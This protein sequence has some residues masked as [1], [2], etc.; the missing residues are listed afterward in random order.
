MS[1]QQRHCSIVKLLRSTY[2]N[3]KENVFERAVRAKTILSLI[4]KFFDP[5]GFNV[6]YFCFFECENE[7]YSEE[8]ALAS[9]EEHHECVGL[10]GKYFLSVSHGKPPIELRRH[11][12]L[13]KVNKGSRIDPSNAWGKD[14]T[15]GVVNGPADIF[16]TIQNVY[17]PHLA[18]YTNSACQVFFDNISDAV[19]NIE[20]YV[21]MHQD[22]YN[23]Y[24]ESVI[25]KEP[26]AI[27]PSIN[28]LGKWCTAVESFMEQMDFYYTRKINCNPMQEI[29]LWTTRLKSL[30]N[31]KQRCDIIEKMIGLETNTNRKNE[32]RLLSC[33][34][35]S[36]RKTCS[37]INQAIVEAHSNIKGLEALIPVLDQLKTSNIIEYLPKLTSIVEVL[38]FSISNALLLIKNPI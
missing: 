2:A 24:G 22:Q 26:S 10:E 34:V 17:L 33:M 18:I 36:W 25:K 11:I 5:N 15:Y 28:L 1:L 12:F 38:S 27:L 19:Q 23:I 16:A 21:S 6:I 9:N 30:T 7:R 14:L 32:H 29:H 4:N 31:M 20:V 13:R 37:N 8:A 3:T 35:D